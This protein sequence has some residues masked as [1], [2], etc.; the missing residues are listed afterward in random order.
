MEPACFTVLHEVA[1]EH[2]IRSIA[3]RNEHSLRS[4]EPALPA[5]LVEPGDLLVDSS[6]RLHVSELIDR[7]GHG[8]ILTQRDLRQ[9]REE[10]ADL[11]DGSAVAI[12]FSV[13]LLERD[14]RVHRDRLFLAEERAEQSVHDQ[15]GLVEGAP[16]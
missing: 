7:A 9:R 15:D 2:E 6:D 1:V 4:R 12:H 11:G 14:R 13:G 10:R 5:H 8:E 16:G 3:G